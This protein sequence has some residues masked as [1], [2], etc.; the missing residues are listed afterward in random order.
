MSLL[1]LIDVLEHLA[2]LCDV[3]DKLSAYYPQVVTFV[4]E[5]LKQV[6]SLF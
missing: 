6:G 5:M 2:T 3:L 1:K 4:Q